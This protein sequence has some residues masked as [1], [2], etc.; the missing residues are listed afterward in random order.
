MNK[1]TI[2]KRGWNWKA[3]WFSFIWYYKK[4]ITGKAFLMAVLIFGTMFIGLLP[5][6][7][8]CGFKGNRDFYD[9]VCKNVIII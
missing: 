8:Y 2:K 4:G 7:I 1:K 3:F 9:H 6:M 5:V